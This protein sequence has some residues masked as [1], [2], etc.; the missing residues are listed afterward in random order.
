MNDRDSMLEV[1][2]DT[3]SDV[4]A[5][6]AADEIKDLDSDLLE[7]VAGGGGGTAVGWS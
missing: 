4:V 6:R 2:E 5:D 7:Q 1:S 3:H